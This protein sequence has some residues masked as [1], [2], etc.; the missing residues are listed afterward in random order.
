MSSRQ[1][2]HHSARQKTR[3]RSSSHSDAQLRAAAAAAAAPQA[4]PHA[5]G[6][7]SGGAGAGLAWADLPAFLFLRG[8]GATTKPCRSCCGVAEAR[9]RSSSSTSMKREAGGEEAQCTAEA[10][11]EQSGEAG[12]CRGTMTTSC[13]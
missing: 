11:S 4:P 3:M 1:H 6:P 7:S 12:S 9:S 13:R 5:R 10:A 2:E 8:S